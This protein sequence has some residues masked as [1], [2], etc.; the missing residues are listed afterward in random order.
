MLP[1]F[2]IEPTEA[3]LRLQLAVESRGPVLRARLPSRPCNDTALVS[4]ITASSLW[5]GSP[6]HVVIDADASHASFSALLAHVDPL[7]VELTWVSRRPPTRDRFLSGLGDFRAVDA[8]LARSL[9][10]AR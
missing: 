1:V 4:L 6:I 9:R 10:G 5:Y 7:R 3:E 2:S 8:L